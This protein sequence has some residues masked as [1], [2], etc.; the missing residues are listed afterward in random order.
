MTT[1]RSGKGFGAPAKNYI[2]EKNFERIAGKHI[3]EE[4]NARP[5]VWGNTLEGI[6]F[7]MLGIEYTLTSK[8][9]LKHPTIANWYGSADGTREDK[10]RAVIDIKC[11][12][13]LKSFI[14]LVLPLYL[15]LEE[16]LIMDALRHGF[17]LDGKEYPAH[18]SAE[19]YYWQLVSN[20]CINNTDWAEL[21]VFM[22]YLS[23]IK[24]I[25]SMAEGDR[26]AY[27]IWSAEDNELPSIQ[28]GGFLK[29]INIIRF[30]V[31]QADKDLLT[32]KVQLASEQ[33]IDFKDLVYTHDFKAATA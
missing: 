10:D 21:I 12:Y 24:D 2:L 18:K 8:E 13:T 27:F 17:V 29:N 30:Q 5:L 7:D 15:G 19:Q 14:Q 23:Q 11:P 20:A 6:L 28:D 1:D 16:S 25:K 9:T 32:S 22:P 26:N 33:L 31:P 4:S 3:S